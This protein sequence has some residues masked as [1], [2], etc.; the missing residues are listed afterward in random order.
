[1]KFIITERRYKKKTIKSLNDM[2]P[3][4]EFDIEMEIDV[5]GLPIRDEPKKR[6]KLGSTYSVASAVLFIKYD[7]LGRDVLI[8]HAITDRHIEIVEQTKDD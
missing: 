3:Q 2:D 8:Q 6:I 4:I 5:S 7:V 1:M